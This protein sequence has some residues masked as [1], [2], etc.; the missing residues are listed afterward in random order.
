MIWDLLK[1]YTSPHTLL[2]NSLI[3]Y[4]YSFLKAS[5]R[6]LFCNHN[7]YWN[8]LAHVAMMAYNLVPHSSAGEAP[9]YLMFGHNTFYACT[10]QTI[11]TKT[12]V[13]GWWS[14]QN[15]PGCHERNIHD[16]NA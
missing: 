15:L 11:I 1:D 10:L 7:T 6:K 5:I 8:E 12:Q 9:I 14:V 13:H 2:A 4:T 3:E 16:G